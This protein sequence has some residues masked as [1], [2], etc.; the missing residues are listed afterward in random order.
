LEAVIERIWR[1][2]WRPYSREFGDFEAEMKRRWRYTWRPQSSKFG[3]VLGGR[4]QARLEEYWEAVNLEVV[5]LEA[6]VR[7]GGRT[8]AETLFFSALVTVGM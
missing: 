2:I 7:E 4:D 5:N 1:C 6:V 8:G 3:D